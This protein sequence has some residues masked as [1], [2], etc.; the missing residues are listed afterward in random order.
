MLLTNTELEK[1]SLKITNVL[2]H[3]MNWKIKDI[4][5]IGSGVINAVF[6]IKD[7]ERGLLAV[8][9]PWRSEERMMDKNS[10][11]IISLQKEAGIAEHCYKHQI[12]VPKIHKLY[13]SNEINFLVSNFVT[14]DDH[15]ISSFD[16]GK[17]TSKIHKLP[18]DGL[19]IIDQQEQTLSKIISERITE[20]V[21]SL[22][23][24]VYTDLFVPDSGELEAILNTSKITNC[25]LH[26]DVRRPNIIAKNGIIQAI[27]DWDN[28]FIGN[29]IMELMRISETQELDEV[30][31][32]KGYNA[33]KLLKNTEKV[34]QSIYRLDTALML[35]IL[36]ISFLNDKEK[37]EYYI[38]RVQLLFDEINKYL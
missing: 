19:T 20:R 14:G 38:N 30:E 5:L 24:L 22:R 3:E 10:S 2:T 25:L 33:E 4:R 23:K 6:L 31:F 37:S 29:P 26:L 36:F 27:I 17:L 18:T 8:R 35:S 11:G 1:L 32:L 34:I 15:E 21:V 9:T 12:P 16:V 13:F 28:A 7:K